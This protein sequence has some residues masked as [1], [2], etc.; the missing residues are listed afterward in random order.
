M[1]AANNPNINGSDIGDIK[2]VNVFVF[3][4]IKAPKTNK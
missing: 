2:K 4:P 3:P 1:L